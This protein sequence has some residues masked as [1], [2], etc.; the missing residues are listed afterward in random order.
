M[1]ANKQ[2]IP[3]IERTLRKVIAKFPADAEPVMTDI[4]LLVSNYTGEIRTYNDDDEE[5]GKLQF[6]GITAQGTNDV[7]ICIDMKTHL[8]EGLD[9][10]FQKTGK[11]YNKFSTAGHFFELPV[12]AYNVVSNV[13]FN[14]LE[15][16][17][18]YY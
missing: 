9:E 12:G 14:K 6:S 4:H 18:L 5:L 2:T 11:L 15:F 13:P 10:S 16:Q 17:A 8:I 1:E 7:Y 3:Q